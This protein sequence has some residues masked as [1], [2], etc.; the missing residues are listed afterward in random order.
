MSLTN[1]FSLMTWPS[2]API[3]PT[4]SSKLLDS[5]KKDMG[6][7]LA[8]E[9]RKSLM[10]I[11]PV[12]QLL[13]KAN[14]N[15][16]ILTNLPLS[17]TIADVHEV[18]HSAVGI[19]MGVES[20]KRDSKLAKMTFESKNDALDAYV[21]GKDKQINGQDVVFGIKR[22]DPRRRRSNNNNNVSNDEDETELDEA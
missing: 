2:D 4:V 5:V 17:T 13:D 10:K 15:E 11:D 16:L 7:R 22:E 1:C 20:S 6:L 12:L 8:Q 18:F 9:Q 19:R 14:T 21:L 3:D